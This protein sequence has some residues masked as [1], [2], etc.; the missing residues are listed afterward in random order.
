MRT[1][2]IY[3]GMFLLGWGCSSPSPSKPTPAPAPKVQL[4][5]ENDSLYTLVVAV[6]DSVMPKMSDISLYQSKISKQISSSTNPKEKEALLNKSSEL[7]KAENGMM[8][9]MNEF[10]NTEVDEAFYQ[11]MSA[12]EIRDYLLSEEK[13]IREV[14]FLMLNS[15]KP[16]E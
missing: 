3:L 11:K 13:K 4:S 6:H 12:A 8:L 2:C 10:K 15:L 5:A 7:K 14:S 9:W 1:L 16:I